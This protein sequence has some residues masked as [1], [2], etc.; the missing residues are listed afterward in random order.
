MLTASGGP[1]WFKSKEE[2]DEAKITDVLRHPTWDMGPKITIDCATMMNKG[3]E[4]IEAAYLF[5]IPIDQIDILVHPESLI[6]GIINLHDGSS[7]SYLSPADMRISIAH[8]LSLSANDLR[9]RHKCVDLAKLAN[10]RFFSPDY[11]RFPLLRLA[12]EAFTHSVQ[13]MIVLNAI[14]EKAVQKFLDGKIA[15]SQISLMVIRA[16]DDVNTYKNHDISTVQGV[17]ELHNKIIR[18][19][20]VH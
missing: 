19:D 15:F 2:M 1:F 5:D 20:E 8:A 11:C 18:K 13:A 16:M 12:R 3:L 7:I 17:L 10:L 14:N 4:V 9:Y 6:H